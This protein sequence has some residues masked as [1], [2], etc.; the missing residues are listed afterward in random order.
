MNSRQRTDQEIKSY[1]IKTVVFLIIILILTIISIWQFKALYDTNRALEEEQQLNQLLDS[2]NTQQQTIVNQKNQIDTA[3]MLLSIL[4]SEDSDTLQ[5]PD[6]I[7]EGLNQLAAAK[8]EE[9]AK[10]KNR[11]SKLIDGLFSSSENVREDSRRAIQREYSDD[12]RLS[13][14]LIQAA[15]GRIDLANKESIYQIIYIL[16]QLSLQSLQDNKAEIAQFLS[17]AEDAGLIGQITQ[18][19]VQAILDR[20]N[21]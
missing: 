19:R 1:K 3:L 12:K 7:L 13:G 5:S 10:Y 8:R 14:R 20:L 4:V 18:P 2:I 16:E 17:N 15:N 11:R 6:D 21:E 9:I